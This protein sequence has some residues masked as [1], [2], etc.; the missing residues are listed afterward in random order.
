LVDLWGKAIPEKWQLLLVW[1]GLR[2]AVAI[3]LILLADYSSK[4]VGR[5]VYGDRGSD[6]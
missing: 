2:G 5:L 6:H 4:L 1:S 3:A